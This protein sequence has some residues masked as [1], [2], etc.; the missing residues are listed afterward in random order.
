M[1]SLPFTISWSS[2]ALAI[3]V[4]GGIGVVFGI[5]PAQKAASLSPIEALRF[6]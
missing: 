6:E 2:I 5:Y 1:M 3:G 4:S